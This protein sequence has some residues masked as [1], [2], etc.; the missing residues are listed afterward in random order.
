MDRARPQEVLRTLTSLA[1]RMTAV[2][3]MPGRNILQC[4]EVKMFSSF[5]AKHTVTAYHIMRGR[6]VL[7]QNRKG[8]VY[9]QQ[10]ESLSSR[11]ALRGAA[12]LLSLYSLF[13]IAGPA[14]AR[15]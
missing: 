4:P 13:S 7:P 11:G 5:T 6:R 9:S 10:A 3:T 1:I 15:S 14:A 12:E 2:L 8:T